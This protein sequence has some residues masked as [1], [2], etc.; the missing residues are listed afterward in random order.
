[1]LNIDIKTSKVR[2]AQIVTLSG[3]FD[4][5]EKSKVESYLAQTLLESP[6]L[7]IFDLSSIALMDSSG[8]G[9]LIVYQN[10]L[11]EA[12][13]RMAFVVDDNNYII[14]KLNNLGIFAD[15]GVESFKTIEEVELAFTTTS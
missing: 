7:L 6:E 14:R 13:T 8:V 4:L 10:K 11:K 9:L 1:M 12:G 5:Y 15:I 2:G 3:E